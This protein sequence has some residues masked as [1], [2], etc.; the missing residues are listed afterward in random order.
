MVLCTV[1]TDASEY[2]SYVFGAAGWLGLSVHRQT[3]VC[4]CMGFHR[5]VS[6]VFTCWLTG[7]F[8][9]RDCPKSA[10]IGS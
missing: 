8:L 6:N 5:M 4:P 2:K 7:I 9:S 10:G 1:S 3:S